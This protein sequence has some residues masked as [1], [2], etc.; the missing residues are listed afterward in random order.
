MILQIRLPDDHCRKFQVHESLLCR[1][2]PVFQSA[3]QGQF[4]EAI[5]RTIDVKDTLFT[6]LE[7]F[8]FW[9]YRGKCPQ[10]RGPSTGFMRF[11]RLNSF[12]EKYDII[13]LKYEAAVTQITR[14]KQ[15][16]YSHFWPDF[17]PLVGEIYSNTRPGD[18]VRTFIVA[19]YVYRTKPKHFKMVNSAQ[20]LEKYPEWLLQW[21]GE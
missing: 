10:L 11:V 16:F 1:A 6:T 19:L 5:S 15:A 12:A 3:L 8:M 2:S 14:V 9:L 18:F 7:D 21:A 20:Y 17:C 13:D 4:G